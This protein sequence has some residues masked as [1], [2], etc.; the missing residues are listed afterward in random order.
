MIKR[1]FIGNSS[2]QLVRLSMMKPSLHRFMSADGSIALKDKNRPMRI[3]RELPN[4][5]DGKNKRIATFVGFVMV[6]GIS[7]SMFVNYERTQLPIVSN[8]MYHM[9]RSKQVRELMGDN[10]DFD[11]VLPWVSGKLNQ[12]AGKVDIKFNTKGSKGVRGIVHL[13]ADRENKDR[14]FLIHEWSLTVGD[15]KVDLLER[16]SNIFPTK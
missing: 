1:G 16:A 14:E 2:R 13:V 12:V 5:Q 15:T 4:P 11:G 9:R 10:I 6:I 7:F 8:T 3:D